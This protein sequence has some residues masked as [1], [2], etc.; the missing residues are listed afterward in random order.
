MA[1]KTTFIHINCRQL[2]AFWAKLSDQQ[3]NV[4][5]TQA[6]PD[7]T[8]VEPLRRSER[9]RQPVTYGRQPL[10]SRSLIPPALGRCSATRQPGT[11]AARPTKLRKPKA[12]VRER[13]FQPAHAESS[14][15]ARR[16]QQ[17]ARSASVDEGDDLSPLAT[18]PRRRGRRSMAEVGTLGVLPQTEEELGELWQGLTEDGVREASRDGESFAVTHL[19]KGWRTRQSLGRNAQP[20]LGEM[21]CGRCRGV[22]GAGGMDWR[23]GCYGRRESLSHLATVSAT[24]RLASLLVSDLLLMVQPIVASPAPSARS[25]TVGAT[26]SSNA[27]KPGGTKATESA[28]LVHVIVNCYQLI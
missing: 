22:Y 11:P 10:Q 20:H 12:A 15:A 17:Q 14:S 1:T 18:T 25:A 2:V 9:T 16:R 26:G 21:M 23:V 4:A 7:Q 24:R 3:V 8:D 19:D 5:H 28:R 6:R 27:S 13:D